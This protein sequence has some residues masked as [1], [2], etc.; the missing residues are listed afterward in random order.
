MYAVEIPTATA[1]TCS[2]RNLSGPLYV[3]ANFHDLH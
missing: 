1:A 2:D 3:S